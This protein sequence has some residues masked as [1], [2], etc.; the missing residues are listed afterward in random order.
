M[1]GVSGRISSIAL[2]RMTVDGFT[3]LVNESTEV[4]VDPRSVTTVFVDGELDGN[5]LV[6]SRVN[7]GVRGSL[8][9]VSGT[10]WTIG[11]TDVEITP[12]TSVAEGA[13][14]IGADVLVSVIR[15]SDDSLVAT[16][17]VL[18]L[19][20]EMVTVLTD[21]E[22]AEG[23]PITE[24]V[25]PGEAEIRPLMVGTVSDVLNLWTVAGAS[26]KVLVDE[27]TDMELGADQVGLVVLIGYEVLNDGSLAAQAIR[28][29]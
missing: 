9:T 10:T 6:A 19:G 29:P 11:T 3:V 20:T 28:I 27:E 5:T 7:E 16:G 21:T 12:D 25:L 17:V 24:I 4:S 18:Q 26:G 13:G 14:V 2:S 22:D 15:R 8:G 23:L 1:V